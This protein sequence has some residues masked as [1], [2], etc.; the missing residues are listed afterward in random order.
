[1][2]FL[3]CEKLIYITWQLGVVSNQHRLIYS[4]AS[5]WMGIIKDML[6][7]I[8]TLLQTTKVM[9]QWKHLQQK[10]S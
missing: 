1:M 4:A 3:E 2:R 7:N 8:S 5:Q 9:V 6:N 10:T